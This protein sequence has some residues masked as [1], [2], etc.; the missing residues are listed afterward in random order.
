LSR[1]DDEGN[2]HAGVWSPDGRRLAFS[3][4]RG[5]TAANVF[6]RNADGTAPYQPKMRCIA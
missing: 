6:V 2:P 5:G 1:I 3:S 4:S